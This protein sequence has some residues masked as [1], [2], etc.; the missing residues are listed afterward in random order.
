MTDGSTLV[1]ICPPPVCVGASTV[2]ASFS[3]AKAQGD[4]LSVIEQS[5]IKAGDGGFQLNVTGK[6]QLDGGVVS[7]SDKAIAAGA[8]FLNTAALTTSDIANHASAS[9]SSSGYSLSSDMFQKGKY[10]ASK[11][12][13]T[14][15]LGSTGD[16]GDSSGQTRG[17]VSVGAVTIG[18][19]ALQLQLSGKSS[20]EAIAGLNRDT[21][22]AHVVAQKQDVQSMKATV[23]ADQAIKQE[24]IKTVTKLTDEAY[25]SRMEVAPGLY[26]VECLEASCVNAPKSVTGTLATMDDVKNAIDP[27][28]VVSVN[29]I[30]NTLDRALQLTYQNSAN[31]DKTPQNPDG[32]K[33]KTIFLMH[34]EK[35]NNPLSE[36]MGVGYEKLIS[37]LDY[38]AANF[39]GYT[40]GA[41]TYALLLASRG[42]LPTNS[43]GHSR[44]TLI[45][46]SAFTILANRLNESGNT[47]TNTNL[48]V[49]GVGGAAN[50]N[51]YT[52]AAAK[53][54]NNPAKNEYITYSYFSNDPVSTSI[55]S[56][57]NPGSWTVM[58]LWQ[59]YDTSH[60]MH[61]CYGSG[62]KDCTQVETPLPFGPKG[63]TTGN[64]MLI[65]YFGGVRLGEDKTSGNVNED[66][67]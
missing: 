2:G 67:K 57:A 10:G 40:N 46:Q 51:D 28:T 17:A 53:I 55:F 34:V 31:I 41:E 1:S 18:D 54:I 36:L 43:L 13:L 3:K 22:N 26:K 37:S 12:V 45:Q 14:N 50:V 24:T 42:D 58:D 47:Y 16:E 38:G 35:A 7:S 9:A 20:A 39:L 23:E 5:G 32:E 60:S 4:F 64:A 61:S 33:P 8:N 15:A 19:E 11:G 65:Q 63:T 56:G 21:A 44:G 52:A 48:T 59:V 25:R 29:G 62:A 66:N 6:T 49:R 27:N 30:F